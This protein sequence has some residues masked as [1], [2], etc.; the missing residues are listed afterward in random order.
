MARQPRDARLEERTG[1]G[2]LM[3]HAVVAASPW[4]RSQCRN[5][6][7]PLPIATI[8]VA[9]RYRTSGALLFVNLIGHVSTSRSKNP[10]ALANWLSS[11]AYAFTLI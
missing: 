6:V 8:T 9:I 11:V 10:P 1:S 3:V 2:G 4:R 7:A 5:R